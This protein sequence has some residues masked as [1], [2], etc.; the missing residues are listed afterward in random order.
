MRSKSFDFD[1]IL[2][3][4]LL[5]FSMREF[6]SL[7]T[8]RISSGHKYGVAAKDFSLIHIPAERA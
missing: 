3:D 1:I 5:I 4:A 2:S 8:S 6:I 7:C